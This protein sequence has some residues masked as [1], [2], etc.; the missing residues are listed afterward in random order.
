MSGYWKILDK[1]GKDSVAWVYLLRS[2]IDEEVLIECVDAFDPRYPARE[3]W[4]VILSS[5]KG[6]PVRCRFCDAAFYFK[7]NLSL[8]E[9]LDQL[10][11]VIAPHKHGDDCFCSKKVKLHFA[12]MGEPALNPAVLEMLEKI[13]FIYPGVNFIPTIATVAPSG[14]ERWFKELTGIKNRYYRNG[15]FQLQFSVNSTDQE[16]RNELMP[17][18]KWSFEQI[19]DFGREYFCYGDRK[20]TLNFAL[21]VDTPFQASEILAH[22]DP[23]IF[24]VKITPVNPT[25]SAARAKMVSA[26]NFDGSCSPGLRAELKKLEEAGFEVIISIGSLEEI[27]VGS[28]CGQL[29]FA[30]YEYLNKNGHTA[31]I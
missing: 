11:V 26:L 1:K 27:G 21:A 10:E 20:I 8:D 14:S 15:R 16:Y 29:A 25:A 18:K 4:V 7:G 28:N 19:R 6:C 5:Q 31:R 3:K 12:R 13:P 17:V 22:F 24:L 2:K 9:L 30:E 23:E